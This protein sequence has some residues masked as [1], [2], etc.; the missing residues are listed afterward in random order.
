MDFNGSQV[1]TSQ[2]AIIGCLS[3]NPGEYQLALMALFHDVRIETQIPESG[4]AV[5]GA[6]SGDK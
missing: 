5:L 3:L 1:H 2:G 6:G 4:Q